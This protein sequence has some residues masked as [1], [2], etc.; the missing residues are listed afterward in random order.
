MHAPKARESKTLCFLAQ[1]VHR[2]GRILP[3]A[4]N[5]ITNPE[6]KRRGGKKPLILHLSS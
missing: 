4:N 2:P 5:S 6:A 3:L 1:A